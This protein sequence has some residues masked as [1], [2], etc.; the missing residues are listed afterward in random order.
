M[1]SIVAGILLE[2]FLELWP[3]NR[4]F[5]FRG[6]GG[7]GGRNVGI[8]GRSRVWK[9]LMRGADTGEVGQ[10][11]WRGETHKTQYASSLSLSASRPYN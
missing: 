3:L 2:V 9:S 11:H 6:G 8:W 10:A 5:F 4:F 7:G 1:A